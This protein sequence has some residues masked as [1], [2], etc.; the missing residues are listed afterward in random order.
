MLDLDMAALCL[1]CGEE[2]KVKDRRLLFSS[3]SKQMLLVWQELFSLSLNV[4]VF[5]C[6]YILYIPMST[7]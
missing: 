3:I 5:V 7:A 6:G 1:G 2:T 4:W